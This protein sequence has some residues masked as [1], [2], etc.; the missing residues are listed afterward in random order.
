MKHVNGKFLLFV[1]IERFSSIV[2]NLD[3]TKKSTESKA[4]VNVPIYKLK[5][6]IELT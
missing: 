6:E 5:F 3:D 1:C 4:K 2:H